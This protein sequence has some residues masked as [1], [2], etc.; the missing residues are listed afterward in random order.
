MQPRPRRDSTRC[1][2]SF[3]GAPIS[4]TEN[5][6]HKTKPQTPSTLKVERHPEL[7]TIGLRV[8]CLTQRRPRP[9]RLT[10]ETEMSIS[11]TPDSSWGWTLS[12]IHH[13]WIAHHLK[14]K[15]SGHE[16]EVSESRNV[17]C[18]SLNSNERVSE[19]TD[20]VGTACRLHTLQCLPLHWRSNLTKHR[21]NHLTRLT[22]LAKH[23]KPFSQIVQSD[24]ARKTRL[25]RSSIKRL[26]V[27]RLEVNR[28]PRHWGCAPP[29]KH[30]L[31][32]G[33]FVAWNIP[34][35]GVVCR[36]QVQKHFPSGKTN[37]PPRPTLDGAVNLQKCSTKA[38]PHKGGGWRRKAGK[39][40][41]EAGKW[42]CG[43]EDLCCVLCCAFLHST[44]AH[45]PL[46][47]QVYIPG[48]VMT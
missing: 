23:E 22:N 33:Q 39:K 2:A 14:T 48:K 44:R 20:A 32:K 27:S 31:L 26:E 15:S 16:N 8:T 46:S 5:T 35:L 47:P 11:D 24:Q 30:S 37:S 34:Q 6:S 13:N 3:T 25:T 19:S 9:A 29:R 45:S 4:S 36:S 28:T 40:I 42:Q 38:L 21:K 1:N 43:T 18:L 41:S 17:Q 12:C 10:E 7:S